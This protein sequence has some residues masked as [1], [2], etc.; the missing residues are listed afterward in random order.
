MIHNIDAIYD[1]G[2][3]RPVEPLTLPEGARVHLRV[4]DENGGPTET[5]QKTTGYS[6]WL[7]H[8]SGRWQ[9]EFERAS[10]GDFETRESLS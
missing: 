10:E 1:H 7:N 9:G 6:D 3:F 4:E 5:S 8:L 2:V